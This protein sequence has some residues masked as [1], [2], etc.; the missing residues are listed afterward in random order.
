MSYKEK[1]TTMY[2]MVNSGQIL[3]A[4]EKYYHNDVVMQEMGEAE[5]VGKDANREYEKNFVGSVKAI[6]GGGV[7][8][9]TS[10]E[11]NGV[12]MV[13]SWMDITFQNDARVK[14]E[15]VAVQYWKGDQIVKERFYH[16]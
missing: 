9:I 10:D 2:N 12:T 15:Q 4:F 11:S 14:L 1:V 13:E 8:A 6:N 3:D 16:K 7:D 5:R